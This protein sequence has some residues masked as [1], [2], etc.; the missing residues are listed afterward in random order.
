MVITK[1]LEVR[2]TGVSSTGCPAV[3]WHVVT[4][5]CIQHRQESLQLLGWYHSNVETGTPR[6]DTDLIIGDPGGKWN[7]ARNFEK[8]PNRRALRSLT[9]T[10]SFSPP[11]GFCVATG[12]SAKEP[13]V[14]SV[15]GGHGLCPLHNAHSRHDWGFKRTM[16]SIHAS[17]FWIRLHGIEIS[18]QNQRDPLLM[19]LFWDGDATI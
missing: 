5:I 6:K 16:H 19:P 13:R 9:Q 14:M 2:K 18:L 1:R 3:W 8:Q 15:C 10:S 4:V 11:I 7:I 12:Y 17:G